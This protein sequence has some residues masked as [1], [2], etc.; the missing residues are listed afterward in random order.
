MSQ[1]GFGR[2]P[3]L[4]DTQVA[5]TGRG[6]SVP[7]SSMQRS[8]VTSTGSS[9]YPTSTPEGGTRSG[10]QRIAL[11]ASPASPTLIPKCFANR[12]AIREISAG[13]WDT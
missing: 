12:Y 11:K 10:L 1:S 13:A 5:P 2:K 8:Q 7:I 9:L 6:L 3:C 4:V